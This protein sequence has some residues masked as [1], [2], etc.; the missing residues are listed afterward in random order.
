MNEA[1]EWALESLRTDAQFL[2]TPPQIALACIFHFEK[3]LV[4]DFLGLKFPPGSA[5]T[6]VKEGEK[7]ED[8]AEMLLRVI[9]E[10][11]ELISERLN[12]IRS[13]TKQET[14]T[15]V[16]NI[17]KR[18]YQCRKLLDSSA[19]SAADSGSDTA[20]KRKADSSEDRESKK[21]RADQ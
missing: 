4:R 1:R 14:V 5:L 2:Y 18:L 10:C 11:D 7:K 6:P 20:A 15:L 13:R 19:S 3:E 16:T 8:A 12:I 9:E 17:D 21:P